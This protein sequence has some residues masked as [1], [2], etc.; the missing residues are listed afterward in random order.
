M[1]ILKHTTCEEF[2][3]YNESLLLKN[4]SLNNLI[5]GLAYMIKN[6]KMETTE[7]LYYSIVKNEIVIGC[8]LRSNVDKPLVITAMAELALDLLIDDL[9]QNQI[10]L[11]SVVGEELSSTYFKNK[12]TKIKNL[13]FKINMHLGVYECLKVIMPKSISGELIL[14]TECD[15]KLIIDYVTGFSRDCFPNNPSSAERIESSTNL[16]LKNRSL[17]LLKSNKDEILSMAANS[18]STPNSGTI[19]LVYTPPNLRGKGYGSQVVALLTDKIIRDGKKFTNLFA[20]LTNPT[21]N[22]IY[23]KIGY[24]KIGQSIHFD[25]F[26]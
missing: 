23:Q 13:N 22:S 9:N 5:L 19:S 2:L 8:A 14:A 18:R 17:F 6:K 12:W 4:E 16:H 25:F 1:K 20:D 10:K 7:P 11:A 3:V 21:S 24:T 26:G 15:K